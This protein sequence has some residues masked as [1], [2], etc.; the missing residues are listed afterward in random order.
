MINRTQQDTPLPECVERLWFFL[1]P[2][3]DLWQEMHRKDLTMND[4]LYQKGP[5]STGFSEVTLG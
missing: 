5:C 2:A 3:F 1:T 4:I